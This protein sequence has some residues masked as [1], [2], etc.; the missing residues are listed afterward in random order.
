[1]RYLLFFLGLVVIFSQPVFA[2]ESL[3]SF[4]DE[5]CRIMLRE[6]EDIL[7][8]GVYTDCGFDDEVRAWNTWAPY[9]SAHKMKRALYELCRRYPNHEYGPLYCQKAIDL[10]Y[11]P[12]LAYQGFLQLKN[13]DIDNALTSFT[14]ALK[15]GDLT[16]REITQITETLG[17][18]YIKEGTPYYNPHAGAALLSKAS[19]ERSA[20]ANNALGY[21]YFTGKADLNPDMKEA[22][23]CFWRAILL[24][25]PAAEENLGV[26]H[27]VRQNKI[28]FVDAVNYMAPQAFTC[29]PTPKAGAV[30]QKVQKMDCPCEDI[31]QKE[32]F[33]QSQPYLY[34][35]WTDDGK[36]VLRDK[37]GKEITVQ[38][39]SPVGEDMFVSEIRPRAVI[40]LQSGSRIILNRY[41]E[42]ECVNYCL[43]Q[44]KNP[45]EPMPVTIKP[46]RL[47]FTPKE[48]SDLMY[49]ASYLV[50]TSLPYIGREECQKYEKKDPVLDE[51]TRLL[52]DIDSG[53]ESEKALEE[54]L[55]DVKKTIGL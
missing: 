23:T 34:V 39:G 52:L 36:A 24:G 15:T 37:A 17:L 35:N 26:F 9:A 27:L 32:S 7:N 4:S 40:L 41:H 1:M 45:P 46:Y 14:N 6:S 51:A 25:C 54:K 30:P 20:V 2:A 12:A 29:E 31:L 53:S 10:N 49:Y 38:T 47:S 21:L 48:C 44:K 16:S 19:G 8:E 28:S 55:E 3:E 43:E 13:G 18:L 22:F 42:G 33:F 50:D 5:K 11:G